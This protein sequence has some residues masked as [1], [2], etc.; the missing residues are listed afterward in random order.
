MP[1]FAALYYPAWNPPSAWLRSSLLFFDKIEFIIPTDVPA[2]YDRANAEVF[3]L[4]PDAVGEVRD[5][6]YDLNL[7]NEAEERIKT[8]FD[9]IAENDATAS[10]SELR[11][12]SVEIEGHTWL[13]QSKTARNI[14]NLL[15]ER[16]LVR[17]FPSDSI[18]RSGF[19]PVNTK[20]ANLILSLIADQY[21][22]EKGVRTI[23]DEELDFSVVSLNALGIDQSASAESQLACSVIQ[24]SIPRTINTLSSSDYVELRKRFEQVRIPFQRAVREIC[25][26]N[27]LSRIRDANELKQ[28][29]ESAV[30]EF[31][32]SVEA[33]RRQPWVAK[34]K[35]WVEFGIGSMSTCLCLHDDWWLKGTGAVASVG[36]L[37]YHKVYR[38]QYESAA[39]EAHRLVAGMRE[40]LLQPKL[41]RRLAIHGA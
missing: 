29:I 38:K 14:Y 40:K 39:T 31:Y 5:N 1:S 28:R 36:L 25:D 21:A 18:G 10:P 9:E 6:S 12:G 3:D 17:D 24:S 22:A 33:L 41:V 37:L 19:W 8:A 2:E 35:E 30:K 11:N 20:A 15:E 4:L 32:D 7:S 26:D 16:S 23:T 13:H 34:Y 27:M